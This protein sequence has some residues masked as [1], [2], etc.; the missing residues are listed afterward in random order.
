MYESVSPL[1]KS[2]Q[3]FFL[4][5]EFT[6]IKKKK[7]ISITEIKIKI[8]TTAKAVIKNELKYFL[9]SEGNTCIAEPKLD[10][11]PFI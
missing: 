2:S 7:K 9:L 5:Y 6:S 1:P 4:T 8:K 3:L 10:V 11:L